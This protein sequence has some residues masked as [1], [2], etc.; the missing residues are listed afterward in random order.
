MTD[1]QSLL[2]EEQLRPVLQTEGPVLVLAGAGSGKTRVL[3]YRIAHLI[4]DLN[5]PPRNILAITFTN[6]AANEMKERLQK[7][8]A[9]VSSMWICTIHGMC[10]RMLRIY[11]DRIGYTK[12]FSIYTETE[13]ER[14]LKAI[15]KDFGIEEDGFLKNVR[16]HISNA[17]NENLS[18]EEYLREWQGSKDITD[19][20]RVFVRYEE[21]LKSCNALDFDDLLNK[22]YELVAKCEEARTYFCGKFRYI[23]IDEFQDTNVVQY[24]LVKLLASETRNLFAVG[25]DDQ[26]I[27]GF[28]GAKVENVF[29]FQKDFPEA[30]V[31][32]LE[33]NYRSTKKILEAA[34][35]VI[36]NNLSR[37]DKTLYTENDDG[38]RIEYKEGYD[39]S[40]EAGYVVG[41][42]NSLKSYNGYRNSDFAVL[43]RMNALSR[44]FEQECLKYGIPTKV[45][46]GFKFFER[47]EVKDVTAYLRLVVN[48]FDEE[49]LLRVINVPKR[50][51]GDGAIAALRAIAA[52]DGIGLYDVV[53]NCEVE[54]RL[55]RAVANKLKG[56]KDLLVDLLL[57][58]ELLKLSDFVKYCIEAT[59]IAGM[60]EGDDDESRNKR[61][62]LDEFVNSV[63]EFEQS[64]TDPDNPE[65]PEEVTLSDYLATVSLSSDTDEDSGDAVTIA[66][67]HAVKGLEFR[68]VFI[69]G[70]D[71]SIFPVTKFD[72]TELEEERRLMYVAITR[73]RERLYLTRARSRFLYGERKGLLASPFLAELQPVLPALAEKAAR[74]A[75]WGAGRGYAAES[76]G[77]TFSSGA[78]R[79]GS[80]PTDDGERP[81]GRYGAGENGRAGARREVSNAEAFATIT[82]NFG[83][84]ETA[85]AKKDFAGFV[86]GARV[87]HPK[88]GE[89]TVIARKAQGSNTYCDIAF[90][91][92]GIKTLALEYAPLKLLK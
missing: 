74:S 87:S 27:Y 37:M 75:P 36:K 82:K 24:N 73:A 17:K 79:Y 23:H 46:G 63:L 70:L 16:W 89:G 6:K 3:T 53:L 13:K 25:D 34:N 12:D 67:V 32:K 26:S 69:C 21:K 45:F 62:N 4:D 29:H 42:I 81:A 19:V 40:E 58:K 92:V 60:Y 48:P 31:F 5:V 2:N 57:N 9:D 8:G 49:S 28:R 66:T 22:A 43:M 68:V 86:T 38:V 84:K 30:K 41:V 14:V 88:F 11:G 51:L 59:G 44:A 15:I 61:M 7:L 80:A 52:E 47:K 90:K 76:R 83:R 50:G 54:S 18:P 72:E 35:L 10:N 78:G 64:M 77:G 33:R 71:E 85:A 1:Y 55:S 20:A 65:A 39:E 56:F 91:G